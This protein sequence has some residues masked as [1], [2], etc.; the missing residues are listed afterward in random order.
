MGG[1]TI[2]RPLQALALGVPSV[3]AMDSCRCRD[4]SKGCADQVQVVNSI[5]GT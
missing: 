3:R 4:R 5:L 1:R 2:V